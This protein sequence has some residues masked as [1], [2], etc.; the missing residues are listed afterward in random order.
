MD[1]LI[2]K[3]LKENCYFDFNGQ[4]CEEN[5]Y[6]CAGWDGV[7]KRCDC[8]NRKVYWMLTKEKDDVYA[9]AD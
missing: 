6:H 8:G 1:E 9:E 3:K 2:K 4:N 7:S 5:G